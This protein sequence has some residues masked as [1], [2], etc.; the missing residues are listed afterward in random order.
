[1]AREAQDAMSGAGTTASDGA[2]T[3]E[4]VEANHRRPQNRSPW[5]TV[6]FASRR[7]PS[8]KNPVVSQSRPVEKRFFSV[9]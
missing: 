5:S 2:P 4:V 1:M 7:I 9:P 3:S 8:R 6:L